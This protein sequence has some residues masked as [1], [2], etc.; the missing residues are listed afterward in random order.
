MFETMNKLMLAGLGALSMTRERAEKIFDEYV[1]R[2]EAAR[3][4]REG[5]VRDLLDSAKKAR[6]DLEGIVRRQMR[7]AVEELHLATREDL[8]RLEMK[9]DE[10]LKR[11]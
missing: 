3:A 2:G 9:L 1:Q 8:A 5:F 11:P 10:L 4:D 6:E 7:Q